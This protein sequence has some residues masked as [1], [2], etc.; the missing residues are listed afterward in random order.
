MEMLAGGSIGKRGIGE[1]EVGRFELEA[2]YDNWKAI[3]KASLQDGRESMCRPRR[4]G[5]SCPSKDGPQE[6][7]K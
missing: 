2:Q 7:S 3:G 5:K 6:G 1:L 4:K